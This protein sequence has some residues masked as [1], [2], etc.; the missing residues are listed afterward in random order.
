MAKVKVIAQKNTELFKKSFTE[1][2]DRNNINLSF[3]RVS[4]TVMEFGPQH[5]SIVLKIKGAHNYGVTGR[6]LV[7]SH[8]EYISI[9]PYFNTMP[10]AVLNIVIKIL[11]TNPTRY[12]PVIEKYNDFVFELIDKVYGKIE[13]TSVDE[14]EVFKETGYIFRNKKDVEHILNKLKL[15]I[16]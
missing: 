8:E 11:E 2:C 3:D 5:G 4:K 7:V 9:I 13:K 15:S 6:R 1:I 12:I 14:D 10:V 16:L